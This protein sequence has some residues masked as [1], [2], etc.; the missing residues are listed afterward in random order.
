MTVSWDD[1][2][3]EKLA[4]VF[5]TYQP[6]CWSCHIAETFRRDHPELVTDRPARW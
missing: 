2:P 4:D 6:V 5:Q 1:V 3:P